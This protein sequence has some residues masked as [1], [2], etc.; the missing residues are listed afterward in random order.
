[1]SGPPPAEPDP[2]ALLAALR[3]AGGE[4]PLPPL[5]LA[6]APPSA[7]SGP[8]GPLVGAA[9]R[10]VLRLLSPVLA[11]LLAQLERDRHRV[12]AELARLE[13]RVGRLEG[14]APAGPE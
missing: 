2:D 3:E 12:R 14:G 6:D 10:A 1:V 7:R 4:P 13:E 5:R 8:A 11:D 9:R